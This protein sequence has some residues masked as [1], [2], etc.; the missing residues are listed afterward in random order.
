MGPLAAVTA[1]APPGTKFA[2]MPAELRSTVETNYNAGE[3]KTDYRLSHVLLAQVPSGA[4]FL[5][6]V[7]GEDCVIDFFQATPGAME[8]LL[9]PLSGA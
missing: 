1:S 6:F 2:E 9:K 4:R 8:K 5:I 7:T 3:P